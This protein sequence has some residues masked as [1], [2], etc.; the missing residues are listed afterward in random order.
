METLKK[1]ERGRRRG[2]GG[3]GILKKKLAVRW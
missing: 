1:R 2:G 3:E